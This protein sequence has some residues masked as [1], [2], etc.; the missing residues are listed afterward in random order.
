MVLGLALCA[1]VAGFAPAAATAGA[2]VIVPTPQA[3]GIAN[4]T[5]TP[6]CVPRAGFTQSNGAT[7]WRT[8]LLP[9]KDA[10]VDWPFRLTSAG[11]PFYWPAPAPGAEVR[12]N[13]FS[14]SRSFILPSPGQFAIWLGETRSELGYPLIWYDA[15]NGFPLAPASGPYEFPLA[16]KYW[17]ECLT[18]ATTTSE[19]QRLQG[20][21]YV[22]GPR[23]MITS[24]LV[25]PDN[26]GTAITYG[27]DASTSFVTDY[28]PYNIVEYAF[29]FEDDG[30]YDQVGSE[31]TGTATYAPGPHNIRVR[32]KDD[33]VPARYGEYNVLLEVPYARAG[34]PEPN[35]IADTGR[36]TLSPT[37]VKFSKANIKLKTPKTIRVRLL[38]SKGLSVKITGLTKGDRIRAKLLKGKK[39]V[40]SRSASTSTSTKTVRL[41]LGKKGRRTLSAPPTI[42]R[43]VV[44]VDIEGTD[45]FTTTKRVAVRTK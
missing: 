41:K 30:T 39:T 11:D 40:A 23:A 25:S 13:G 3:D 37:G 32:V 6:A 4:A 7:P 12:S 38:R 33:H 2:P 24:K 27:F 20:T 5:E 9:A 34:S 16:G 19:R 45:G 42:K 18:C 14:T 21:M 17:W 31:P 35:P 10:V 43:L 15:G 8:C 22:I 26:A 36:G 29:D 44:N 1:A 28:D